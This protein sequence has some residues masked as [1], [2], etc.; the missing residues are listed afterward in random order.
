MVGILPALLLFLSPWDSL[1]ADK[2]AHVEVSAK[3]GGL[4]GAFAF[5]MPSGAATGRA[6]VGGAL[7]ACLS[8]GAAKEAVDEWDYRIPR[9]NLLTRNRTEGADPLDLAADAAGCAAGVAAGALFG[10]G[11]RLVCDPVN[12][13]LAVEVR[14]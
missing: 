14:W 6:R 4:A 3:V 1:P 10:R 13:A 12:R 9:A 8:V 2:R 5:A 7:A 11:A